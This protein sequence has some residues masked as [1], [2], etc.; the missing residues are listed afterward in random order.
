MKEKG[1]YVCKII[2]SR[3]NQIK[4]S[5][6]TF[7]IGVNKDKQKLFE[8]LDNSISVPSTESE[9]TSK[10][11]MINKSQKKIKKNWTM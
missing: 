6:S 3:Y 7:K 1:E 9:P 8:L 10:P 4:P 11:P 5:N 2:K